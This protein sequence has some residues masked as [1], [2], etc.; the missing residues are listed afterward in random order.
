MSGWGLTMWELANTR[1]S[2]RFLWLGASP[3]ESVERVAIF[4]T[5]NVGWRCGWLNISLAG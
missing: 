1:R 4:L 2:L 3:D 5:E